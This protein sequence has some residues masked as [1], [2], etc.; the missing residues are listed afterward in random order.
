VTA[1][2]SKSAIMLI[3][4]FAGALCDFVTASSLLPNE[5]DQIV[6]KFDASG[7][8]ASNRR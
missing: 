3:V 7:R 4:A 2:P 8:R 1:A 5:G 6:G